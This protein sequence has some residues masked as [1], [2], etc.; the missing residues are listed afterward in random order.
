MNPAWAVIWDLDGIL[1]DTGEF[2]YRSWVAALEREHIPFGYERFRDTFG[3]NNT[4]ILK[5]L[6]GSAYSPEYAQRIA[7][8][9]EE[10]FRA[11]IH[12][13][14]ELLPGVQHWL[15]WLSQHAIPQ[16]VASSAPQ[17]NIDAIVQELGI[18][19]HFKAL[20]SGSQLPGKPDP[21]VFLLAARTLDVLPPRCLV[22]EDA[23]AGVAAAKRAGMTC[24]AVTTTNPREVLQEADVIVERLSRIE[25]EV[26][27]RFVLAA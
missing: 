15:E 26:M 9:K 16:A 22:I 6:L 12:G 13:K 3:M 23:I 1:V 27:E 10:F 14:V 8:Y 21:A 7:D 19:R 5:M 18:E 17:A 11:D 24:L 25:P 20:L 2:H 4:G